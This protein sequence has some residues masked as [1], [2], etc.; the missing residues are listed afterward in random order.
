[1]KYNYWTIDVDYSH[2]MSTDPLCTQAHKQTHIYRQTLTNMCVCVAC[3]CTVFSS[4]IAKYY[5]DY[6][7]VTIYP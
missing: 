2:T 3:V 4:E 5:K 7:Y 6:M 1:M